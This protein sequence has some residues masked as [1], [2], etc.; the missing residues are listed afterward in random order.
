MITTAATYAS[1]SLETMSDFFLKSCAVYITTPL[2]LGRPVGQE[3]LL[4]GFTYFFKRLDIKAAL[5][6]DHIA[7]VVRDAFPCKFLACWSPRSPHSVSEIQRAHQRICSQIE[8]RQTDAPVSHTDESQLHPLFRAV[9]I[10]MDSLDGCHGEEEQRPDIQLV[11]TGDDAHLRSGP[12][13]LD[14][15]RFT[16]WISDDGNI[17]RGRFENVMALIMEWR[18]RED[19]ARREE[20]VEEDLETENE[21]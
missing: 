2:D 15:L 6:E 14:P 8:T 20:E 5:A 16:F 18:W 19:D 7:A 17:L 21:F 1:L 12:I 9:F 4:W 13:D 3:Q 11:R 10:T